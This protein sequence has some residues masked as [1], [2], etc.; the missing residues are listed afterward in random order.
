MENLNPGILKKKTLVNRNVDT[1][2]YDAE[3][4]ESYDEAEWETTQRFY[5]TRFL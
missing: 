3:L 5:Q 1:G 2:F 4:L